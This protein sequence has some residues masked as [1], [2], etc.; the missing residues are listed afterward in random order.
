MNIIK[1]LITKDLLQLKSYRKTLILFIIIFISISISQE[2]T[3]GIEGM[4]VI[5]LTLGLGMFAVAT[6]NYDESAK[7]DKYILTLPLTR[8]EIVLSKY[9]LVICSTT[10]GSIIG[11]IAS[12]ITTFAISKQI[13]DIAEL[14][15]F[16]LGAILGIG[17]VE[18]IQIPCIYKY[19]AEK[20]R[21]Q[22]FIIAGIG[23]LLVGGLFL[24]GEKLNLNLPMNSILN[25]FNNFGALILLLAIVIIYYISFRISNRIYSKKEI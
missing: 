19:G 7:A 18:S 14:I 10:I 22:I 17:I 9:V 5:M 3:K 12:G 23:S 20:G 15:S 13:P 6:F 16:G 11:M 25:F 1:G 2:T 24:V 4:L 21:L 8:K